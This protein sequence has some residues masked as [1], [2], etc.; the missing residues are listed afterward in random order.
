MRKTVVRL[1]E[2]DALDAIELPAELRLSLADLAGIAREGL[3]AVSA[4]AGLAVMNEMMHAEMTERLGA[5]KHARA[6]DR[7]GNWHGS[8][9]GSVVL[10]GRRVPVARPRGRTLD[11]AEIDLETYNQFAADDLLRELVVERMLARVATRRF[12]QVNE[13]VGADLETKARS[14]S[15]SAVSRRF[16]VATETALDELMQSGPA[17]SATS[18]RSRITTALAESPQHSE[19]ASVDST[20]AGPDCSVPVRGLRRWVSSQVHRHE[21]AASM[22]ASSTCHATKGACATA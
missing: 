1:V 13:P 16:K 20:A 6:K 11:G 18:F 2:R 21:I 4:A 14:T 22:N 15:K 12:A 10:G 3:L 5:A 8:A 7:A 17:P 9:P 19:L